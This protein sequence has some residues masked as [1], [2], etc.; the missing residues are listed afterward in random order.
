MSIIC[1]RC[2]GTG[3]LNFEQIDPDVFGMDVPDSGNIDAILKWIETHDDH[4]VQV[5]DCCGNGYEWYGVAGEHYNTE[6]PTGLRGPYAY[7]GG[8]CECH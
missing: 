4:D 3:F 1:T 7:N 2:A 6:D 5:C 8:V